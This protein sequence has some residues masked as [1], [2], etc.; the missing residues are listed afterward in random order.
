MRFLAA[1]ILFLATMLSAQPSVSPVLHS[2]STHTIKAYSATGEISLPVLRLQLDLKFPGGREERC[3]L[4]VVFD[5]QTRHYFWRYSYIDG[6]DTTS[7][8]DALN[9]NFEA[10]Y[11]GTQGLV[12]FMVSSL[13]YSKNHT[14]RAANIAAA[15]QASIEEVRRGLPV[16]EGT[17]FHA[18]V[19]G[20]SVFGAIGTMEFSCAPYPDSEQNCGPKA[21]IVS[22]SHPDDTWRLVLRNRW[23]EE[24]TLDSKFKIVSARRLPDAKQ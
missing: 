20:E 12:D 13:L 15:R 17:G 24:I 14:E 8:L 7:P 21:K 2:E 3:H 5:P 22:V 11:A 9:R 18:D 10:V 19:K 6:N 16:Y 4:I 1:S 23:D